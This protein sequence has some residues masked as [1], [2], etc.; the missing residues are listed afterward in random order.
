MHVQTRSGFSRLICL[1]IPL[2]SSI[3]WLIWTIIWSLDQEDLVSGSPR[4]RQSIRS[5]V[6]RVHT[7]FQVHRS[8]LKKVFIFCQIGEQSADIGHRLVGRLIHPVESCEKSCGKL[9]CK[10]LPTVLQVTSLGRNVV[11]AWYGGTYKG[12]RG[13]IDGIGR[14]VDSDVGLVGLPLG[15]S[16]LKQI[17]E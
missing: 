14:E 5:I 11:P 10:K 15:L 17:K 4:Q 1:R 13:E 6:K 2:E 3:P 7:N 9:L 12:Y 8:S 16:A